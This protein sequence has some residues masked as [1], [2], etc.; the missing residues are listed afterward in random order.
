M[1]E[2]RGRLRPPGSLANATTD[3]SAWGHGC[4]SRGH[5]HLLASRTSR[6]GHL[7]PVRVPGPALATSHLPGQGGVEG[8]LGLDVVWRPWLGEH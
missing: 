5:S 2:S 1:G 7:L 6:H 3:R 4:G 8:S